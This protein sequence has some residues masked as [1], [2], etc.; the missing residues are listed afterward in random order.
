MVMKRAIYI[1][2]GLMA[3]CALAYA[4]VLIVSPLP[5][6]YIDRDRSGLVSIGEALNAIDIGKRKIKGRPGCVE[7]FWLKDGLTAYISCP[8]TNK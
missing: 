8:N 6:P 3:V 4:L 1:C 7:Y 2:I 5:L